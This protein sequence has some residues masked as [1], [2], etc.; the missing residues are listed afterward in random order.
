MGSTVYKTRTGKNDRGGGES[1][2]ATVEKK[3]IFIFFF[4]SEGI[5]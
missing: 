1:L 5:K 4:F 3:N 2:V